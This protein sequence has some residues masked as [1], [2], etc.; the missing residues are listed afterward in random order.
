MTLS[1]GNHVPLAR[2]KCHSQKRI[3]FA[4]V[5]RS[6]V[7]NSAMLAHARTSQPIQSRLSSLSIFLASSS[8]FSFST[9]TLF[10][11]VERK[12]DGERERGKEKRKKRGWDTLAYISRHFAESRE[13]W[14]T[15]VR[16]TLCSVAELAGDFIEVDLDRSAR[17]EERLRAKEEPL[18]ETGSAFFL[19]HFLSISFRCP[20][21]F[22]TSLLYHRI[23]VGH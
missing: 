16:G 19:H 5:V 12:R 17:P 6:I 20:S 3:R 13:N 15:V 8:S 11:R 2:A 18:S 10:R 1:S 14:N 7:W 22:V 23:E 4:W 21:T 9:E